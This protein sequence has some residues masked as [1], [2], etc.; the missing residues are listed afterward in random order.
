MGEFMT[1][2]RPLEP[3]IGSLVYGNGQRYIVEEAVCGKGW[4]GQVLLA[5]RRPKGSKVYLAVYDGNGTPYGDRHI[6]VLGSLGS[7]TAAQLTPTSLQTAQP[8]G[9]A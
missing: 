7:M 9:G 3:A 1:G 4:P 8:T 5:V 2:E 6:R